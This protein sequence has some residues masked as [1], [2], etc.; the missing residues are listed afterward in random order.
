MFSGWLRGIAALQGVMTGRLS[1]EGT[2]V[3][4]PVR[5]HSSGALV[6]W[7]GIRTMKISTVYSEV[8]DHN[9]PTVLTV[10]I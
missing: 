5:N 2:S 3:H 6:T 10:V 9:S 8:I 1:S 7:R 4:V